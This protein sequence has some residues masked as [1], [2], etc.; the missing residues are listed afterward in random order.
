MIDNVGARKLLVI[1]KRIAVLAVENQVL[2]FGGWSPTFH[3]KAKCVWSALWSMGHAARNK[4]GFA[5]AQSDVA[6]SMRI[7]HANG[8]I[9]LKLHEV[10]LG[11]GHVVIVARVWSSDQHHKEILAAEKIFVR[12]WRHHQVAV[13]R[14]PRGQVDRACHAAR[15]VPSGGIAKWVIGGKWRGNDGGWIDRAHVDQ[16]TFRKDRHQALQFGR[17]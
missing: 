9:A 2:S 17:I 14:G 13:R 16:F 10:F 7:A 5:F 1:H 4:H 6:N 8:H 12:H 11:I 15:A 3:H